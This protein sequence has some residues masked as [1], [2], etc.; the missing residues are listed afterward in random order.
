MAYRDRLLARSPYVYWRQGASPIPDETATGIEVTV[1][2]GVTFPDG[3]IADAFAFDGTNDSYGDVTALDLFDTDVLTIELFVNPTYTNNNAPLLYH[4]PS[5][6]SSPGSLFVNH[7]NAIPGEEGTVSVAINNDGISRWTFS[8][9]ALPEGEFHLLALRIDRAANALDVFVD[10][11]P[12]AT[13]TRS[14]DATPGNFADSEFVL[15]T[16][17]GI[18]TIGS[19]AEIAIFKELVSD[20]EIAGDFAAAIPDIPLLAYHSTAD[21]GGAIAGALP[22]TTDALFGTPGNADRLA[23]LT[24]YR[25]I[26][27]KN[28]GEA[29]LEDVRVW[30]EA[31]SAATDADEAIGEDTTNPAQAIAN[32]TTA[33]TGVSFSAPADYAGGLTLGDLDQNDAVPVWLERELDAGA[34]AGVVT[35][36]LGA[37]WTG[38]AEDALFT[39]SYEIVVPVTLYVD[40]DHPDRSDTWTREQAADDP[41]SPFATMQAAAMLLQRGDTLQVE[42]STLGNANPADP[43]DPDLYAG[44]VSD[45]ASVILPAAQN[46]GSDPIR[47]VAHIV[48][49][50]RPKC[51]LLDFYRVANWQF[52]G[53]QK[54]YDRGSGHDN[55]TVSGLQDCADLTFTNILS[56]GGGWN[57]I[58]G[59]GLMHF[60]QCKTYSP[61]LEGNTH[62]LNGTGFHILGSSTGVNTTGEWKF[63]DCYFEQVEGEDCIQCSLGQPDAESEADRGGTLEVRGCEFRN[64]VLNP[65]LT[66]PPHTDC[67]QLLGVRE[68]RIVKNRFVN[69]IQPLIASDNQNGRIFIAGNVVDGCQNGLWAQGTSVLIY[70]QNTIKGLFS[71]IAVGDRLNQTIPGFTQK[72][73][74]VNN[75]AT[76]LDFSAGVVIDP[77]SVVTNNVCYQ[78]P[79]QITPWGTQIDG[80]PEFGTS[81]RLVAAGLTEGDVSDWGDPSGRLELSNSPVHSPGIAGGRSLAGLG[82]T[83]DELADLATDILGRPYATPR[84]VGAFQ[85]D[86]DDDVTPAPRPP[87]ILDLT[88]APGSTAARDTHVTARLLPV[89]GQT[90]DAAT[91]TTTTARVADATTTTALP[92]VVTIGAPDGDRFQL[93]TIDIKSTLNPLREARLWPLVLYTATLNGVEDTDGSAIVPTSWQFRADGPGG[94]AVYPESGLIGG[95]TV[96]ALA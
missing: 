39:I 36:T 58:A 27:L 30:I 91:V 25:C 57:C 64:I 60:D 41:D 72:L 56:T 66:N 49:G 54:G 8:R 81:A 15:M 31:P 65:D 33:P 28:L 22:A 42:P 14:A 80:L 75:I 35:F 68:A 61:F 83:D 48:D 87:Y 94:P 95:W 59:S 16:R 18:H 6:D 17:S 88:P 73:I 2:S 38:A 32:P 19:L 62:F 86:P 7:N 55:N 53:F 79:A 23:G 4:V 26:Y 45:G 51:R 85:S 90:I 1:G 78:R 74:I 5:W 69:S 63:T 67:I 84:D 46:G 50:V 40:A 11:E 71:G 3:P 70:A 47:V 20:E 13:T 10:G 76:S 82:L 29:T 43:V 92:A 9:A 21:R 89:P 93:L 12:V 96:G 77:T 24:D 37:S 44:I 34:G 52:E